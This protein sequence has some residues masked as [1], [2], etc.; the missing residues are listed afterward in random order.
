LRRG[1]DNHSLIVESQ[2]QWQDGV[3]C[4]H[5]KGSRSSPERQRDPFSSRS[6]H[7]QLQLPE[8]GFYPLNQVPIIRLNDEGER[9]MAPAE[10]G[11]LPFWWNGA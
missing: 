8:A 10:W 2:Q 4:H 3:M 1:A 6:N 5:Y 9:E 11:L 7:Y